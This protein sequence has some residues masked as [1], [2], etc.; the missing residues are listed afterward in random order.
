MFYMAGRTAKVIAEH[1]WKHG[2]PAAT[3]VASISAVT[4]PEEEVFHTNLGDMLEQDMP[5][6]SGPILVCVGD[7][8]SVAARRAMMERDSGR[9]AIRFAER[10]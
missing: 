4:R 7:M 6:V 3:P 2:L 8:F 10:R 5:S 1:L 9:A